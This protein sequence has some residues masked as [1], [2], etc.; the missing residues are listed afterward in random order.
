MARP[1]MTE[2][3]FA[4]IL[5]RQVPDAEKRA[6]ADV[7]IDTGVDLA[8]TREQVRAALDALREQA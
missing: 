8:S 5:S 3:K 1:G 4:Y 6:R 7:L 2:E